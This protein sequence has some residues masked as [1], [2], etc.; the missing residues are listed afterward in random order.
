MLLSAFVCRVLFSSLSAV[1]D[2]FAYTF[3]ATITANNTYHHLGMQAIPNITIAKSIT[4]SIIFFTFILLFGINLVL[5]F[6]TLCPREEKREKN[7]CKWIVW[8][9]IRFLGHVFH[10]LLLLLLYCEDFHVP[11][12]FVSTM[13]FGHAG[14]LH[15][16]FL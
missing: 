2:V 5:S 16:L 10:L 13:F 8:G 11:V 15:H 4:P 6:C 9:F 7:S 3:C 12:S 14:S 1:V